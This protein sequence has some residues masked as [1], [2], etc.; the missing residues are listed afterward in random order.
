[1]SHLDCSIIKLNNIHDKK[2]FDCGDVALNDYLQKYSGQHTKSNISRTFVAVAS[3]CQKKVLGFYTLSAGHIAFGDLSEK[4]QKRLT[5]YCIPV[6][7]IG[8]LAVDKT[9]QKQGFGRYLLMN[10]LLRCAQQA[11]ELGIFGVI[12]DAKHQEAKNFYLKYGFS[13]LT[14]SP[15]TLIISIKNILSAG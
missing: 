10:A 14:Y 2:S 13:E 5:Q 4:L 6:A 1:M 8:R 12:V 3:T 11:E 9:V 15:L 7:R